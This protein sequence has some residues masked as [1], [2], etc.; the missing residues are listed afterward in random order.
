METTTRQ[1][2][3]ISDFNYISTPCTYDTEWDNYMFHYNNFGIR[4]M[5]HSSGIYGLNYSHR[6]ETHPILDRRTRTM[7]YYKVSDVIRFERDY[8]SPSL[9]FIISDLNT[10]FCN[11]ESV[12]RITGWVSPRTAI[13]H[14]NGIMETSGWKLNSYEDNIDYLSFEWHKA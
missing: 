2:T 11:N 3:T 13:E 10:R 1:E 7:F 5:E 8:F 14:I 9:H 4:S 6:R 12:G